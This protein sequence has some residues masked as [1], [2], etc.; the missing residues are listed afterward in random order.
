MC[1]QDLWLVR[2]ETATGP[3]RR[4]PG[5]NASTPKANGEQHVE[6]RQRR[7]DNRPCREAW[8]AKCTML[9]RVALPGL[10][11]GPH[12]R[13][14]G[15]APPAT[16]CRPYKRLDPKCNFVHYFLRRPVHRAPLRL[17]LRPEGRAAPLRC[18]RRPSASAPGCA[19]P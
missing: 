19:P 15:L 6:P 16:P 8:V 12:R 3:E 14:Q 18:A 1:W 4:S 17:P 9:H 13:F 5:Q 11:S 2:D 7:P 10:N